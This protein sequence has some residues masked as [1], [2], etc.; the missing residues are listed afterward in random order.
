MFFLNTLN[1]HLLTYHKLTVV[2]H[3]ICFI[4][5]IHLLEYLD[6][7]L[8]STGSH[9]LVLVKIEW[10]TISFSAVDNVTIQPPPL[11]GPTNITNS[12][13][14]ACLE[15]NENIFYNIR[16]HQRSCSLNVITLFSLECPLMLNV[17]MMKITI[18]TNGT[19]TALSNDNRTITCINGAWPNIIT[20][21]KSVNS[22]ARIEI[23][24]IFCPFPS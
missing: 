2:L 14:M 9:D 6:I 8:L 16:I 24:K 19:I 13:V 22:F 20:K 10:E 1:V 17:L 5:N 3:F 15:T 12:S 21:C 18:Y 11:C 4:D 7:V 23:L